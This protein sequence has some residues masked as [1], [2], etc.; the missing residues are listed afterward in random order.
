MAGQ[1]FGSAEAQIENGEYTMDFVRGRL[2][3]RTYVSSYFNCANNLMHLVN[4]DRQPDFET[5]WRFTQ[6]RPDHYTI[7]AIGRR[8]TCQRRFVSVSGNCGQNYIDLWTQNDN[9]GRQIWNVEKNANGTFTFKVSGGRNNCPRN[10]F[11]V[12]N[13]SNN[14]DL[15]LHNDN[16]GK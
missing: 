3:A 4:P 6:V 5:R 13:R 1:M 10:T 9:S 8:E 16:S 14:P 7:E 2:D 15:W 12:G 11:S